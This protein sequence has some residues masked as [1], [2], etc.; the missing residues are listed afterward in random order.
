MTIWVDAD[1]CPKL[2][3]E[4]IYKAVIRTKRSLVMVANHCFHYPSSN[5]IRLVQVEKGVDS[6]D[7]F[8][9]QQVKKNDLVVTADIH[10]ASEVLNKQAL[11]FNPRGEAFSKDTIRACLVMR[12]VNEQLR[13][14]G[15]RS[16]QVKTF[17]QKEKMAFANLLNQYLIKY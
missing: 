17:G 12:D 5:Y 2:I 7:R 9:I 8:I 6:A 4:M 14:M 15:Q 13:E 10:L 16:Y 3:K 1:A 11:A